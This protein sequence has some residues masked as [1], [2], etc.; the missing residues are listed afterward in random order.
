MML[1]GD[2]ETFSPNAV[3]DW[4]HNLPNLMLGASCSFRMIRNGT[5]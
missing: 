1:P 2:E 3:D 4:L 5:N